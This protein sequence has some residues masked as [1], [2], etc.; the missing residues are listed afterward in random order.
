MLEKEINDMSN[1]EPTE[2]DI[3][4]ENICK[5][6]E[7]LDHAL[8]TVRDMQRFIFKVDNGTLSLQDGRMLEQ[9]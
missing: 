9:D 4:R 1:V 7:N 6:T 2:D 8:K 3:V 5:L